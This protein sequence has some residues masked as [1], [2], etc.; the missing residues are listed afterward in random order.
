MNRLL[1]K[2]HHQNLLW[3]GVKQVS[4]KYSSQGCEA[5]GYS[6]LDVRLDGGFPQG[7]TEIQSDTGI[8]EL[9]LLMKALKSA[10]TQ[11]RLVVYIAP[12]GIISSQ[13]LAASDF[14]LD[15]VLLI[16]P[17]DQQE[18]LWSAEQC[19]RSG[20]C[21]SVVMWLHDA[22]EVHQVKRL[23]VAS[24]Q[25]NSH[26]FIFRTQKAESLS[27]PFDL[28]LSLTPDI[29]GLSARINKRRGG[30]ASEDFKLDM[31]ASWPSLVIPS[32]PDNLILFPQRS[33]S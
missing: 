33:A 25:G 6:E 17:K 7:I 9:R 15:M 29:K 4:P 16:Y 14:E 5:T 12:M 28:S 31:S 30:W 11:Q 10:F 19:L 20:A 26:Q 21:H 23:Q 3:Q 13:A 22:L 32:P 1:E 24:R 18:A 27:L 2:L 8:G